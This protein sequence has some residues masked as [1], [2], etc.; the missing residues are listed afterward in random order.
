MFTVVV[1]LVAGVCPQKP[2]YLTGRTWG[3]AKQNGKRIIDFFKVVD[4]PPNIEYDDGSG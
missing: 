1:L 2:D 4:F 3:G